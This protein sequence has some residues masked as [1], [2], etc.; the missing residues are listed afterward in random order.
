MDGLMVLLILLLNSG[1]SIGGAGAGSLGAAEPGGDDGHGEGANSTGS[2]I[3]GA[4][5]LPA[6][7]GGHPA[8][9]RA[10]GRA[11]DVISGKGETTISRG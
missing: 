5:G 10:Q 1:S 9:H 11:A 8:T 3:G 2:T 7:V 4:G 6:A